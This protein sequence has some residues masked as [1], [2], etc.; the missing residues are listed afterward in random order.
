MKPFLT[1]II[2]TQGRATLPRTL[3][4]VRD[5]AGPD[6]VEV[7]VVADT[8]DP[9]F[10]DVRVIAEA[11]G[12]RYLEHDAGHHCWGHC[13]INAA[14]DAATAPYVS[15]NDDDDVYAPGAFKAMKAAMDSRGRL[16]P[17]L[18]QFQTY[19]GPVLWD[20]PRAIETRIG[21]HCIVAPAD[22]CGQWTCRYAGDYDYIAQ[23]LALYPESE[24]MWVP[25][26]IAQQRPT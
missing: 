13:Q 15:F 1:V 11:Y 10:C 6:T 8:H 18:F 24:V 3:A 26:V 16:G 4:S 25:R 19:F 2:P 7:I 21:G 12:A 23:T 17:I 9:L 5:Q 22:R 20:I 14:I